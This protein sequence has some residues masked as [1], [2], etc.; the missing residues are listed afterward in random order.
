MAAH[1]ICR[2]IR[3]KVGIKIRDHNQLRL[4][5]REAPRLTGVISQYN[6]N[7]KIKICFFDKLEG[8]NV[9]KRKGKK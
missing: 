2:A 3:S 9:F 6:G 5:I 7:P 4:K 8:H 1:S